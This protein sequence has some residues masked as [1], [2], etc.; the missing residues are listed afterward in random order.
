MTVTR[1]EFL[2]TAGWHYTIEGETVRWYHPDHSPEVTPDEAVKVQRAR[3]AERVNFWLAGCE[4][5]L[6]VPDVAENER[7]RALGLFGGVGKS[8]TGTLSIKVRA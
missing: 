7:R 8:Y 6:D 1:D 3:E 4:V 5:T 2:L